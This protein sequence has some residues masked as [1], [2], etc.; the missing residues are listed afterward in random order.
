MPTFKTVKSGHL[1]FAM[2]ARA[3]G[4]NVHLLHHA[5]T[6]HILRHGQYNEQCGIMEELRPINNN[7]QY[8][9]Q[10]QSYGIL[11][12]PVT[13]RRGDVMTSTCTFDSTIANRMNITLGGPR[14]EQEICI[15]FIEYYPKIPL[16]YC[17]SFSLT[18]TYEPFLQKYLMPNDVEVAVA[19]L[20]AFNQ[21]GLH[22]SFGKIN[23]TPETVTD[24]QNAL[25][26]ATEQDGF[27][28]NDHTHPVCCDRGGMGGGKFITISYL[29]IIN[30]FNLE[31]K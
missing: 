4:A 8:S 18:S 30:D 19:H 5:G 10:H 6:G 2:S 31:W 21:S 28:W 7:P 24:F 17:G 25:L 13:V 14:N 12:D 26:S 23:W 29:G 20:D 3:H 15:A 27:C 9:S 1:K 16:T 22:E 11:H